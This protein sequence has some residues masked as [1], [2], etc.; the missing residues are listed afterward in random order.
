MTEDI[1]PKISDTSKNVVLG[2]GGISQQQS[3]I[4]PS[5]SNELQDPNIRT[6]IA[7]NVTSSPVTYTDPDYGGLSP[8]DRPPSISN[9]S[10]GGGFQPKT[11]VNRTVSNRS[12][13][14]HNY[15][16]P[17]PT[18]NKKLG[19]RRVG[20]D[21]EVTYKK[22]ETT[23]LIGSIQL[24]LLYVMEN[25]ANMPERDLLIPDF[26]SIETVSFTKDGLLQKTPA[27]NYSEFRF[28]I[29]ASYAFRVFRRI[30]E[31]DTDFFLSSLCSEPMVELTAAGASG[32]IFF[33][34]RDDNFICKTVQHKEAEFLQ[35]LLPAY[36]MNL[37]QNPRTLLPKFFGL[38]CYSCNAK[39]VR[40]LVMNNLLPSGLKMHQKFDLKGS[41]YKRKAKKRREKENSG[42]SKIPTYKDLDFLELHPD[43]IILQPELYQS[44]MNSIQRDCR[45][46]ESFKIMDYSLLIGIHNVDQAI[47][48]RDCDDVSNHLGVSDAE[49]SSTGTPGHTGALERQGSFQGRER[50]IAHST[51][52][53][54]ITVE[55]DSM[56]VAGIGAGASG[57][58]ATN[59]SQQIIDDEI[60]SATDYGINNVWGGIPAKNKKGENLLL[61]VGIIDILQSYRFMKKMEHFWKSLVHDGD[62]ISVHRPGFYAKRFQAFC[63]DKVFKKAEPPMPNS[64]ETRK[65]T[66]FRRGNL[67]RTL[68]KDQETE[69]A[70]PPQSEPLRKESAVTVIRIGEQNSN[71]VNLPYV[72]QDRS[73]G[74][75]SGNWNS[76]APSSAPPKQLSSPNQAANIVVV[77]A[78]ITPQEAADQS[79]F[80]TPEIRSIG[81][82]Q[83]GD[84]D[85]QHETGSVITMT[86]DERVQIFVPSPQGTPYNTITKTS[87]GTPC[88]GSA[89]LAPLFAPNRASAETY[90][91]LTPL[92]FSASPAP[93]QETTDST[94]VQ[95][96]S[97]E[98][99]KIS[100]I[101]SS[102]STTEVPTQ[103][104]DHTI[105]N[106]L[107]S[108]PMD[109]QPV[110][111]SQIHLDVP[112]E[113]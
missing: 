9:S 101:S 67:R 54:S 82:P 90:R 75:I 68:S 85:D 6:V 76:A 48:E 72:L 93:P 62:T 3:N 5:N 43:G 27:H 112:L 78:D 59:T 108:L 50:M 100:M 26:M 105:A 53:E 35:T 25:E 1:M 52:L 8:S 20:D 42:D 55:V 40:L 4:K 32:S 99:I 91:S 88:I 44:L 47:R 106:D 73:K 110:S 109:D 58:S 92:N 65:G 33:V 113:D 79:K 70:Q 28:R 21:G 84:A 102:T 22:F 12:S 38:Y 2:S 104:T 74:S 66:S 81:K 60:D 94:S 16:K 80:G 29:F 41:T 86:S 37:K 87:S 77:N 45:V 89:N 64:T 49:N 18:Y 24:G 63:F 56:S 51:A 71:E 69:V 111:L 103:Q 97:L 34:T 39:N 107:E 14:L 19:H 11:L 83:K 13:V 46:L 15:V 96:T 30:F 31:I 17:P 36:Y 23:Q 10:G 57:V 98:M 7:V 61:F 95:E